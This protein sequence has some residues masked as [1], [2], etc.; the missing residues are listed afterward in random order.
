M[1]IKACESCSMPVDS[2]KYCCYCTTPSG[3]LEPFEKRF[4]ERIAYQ[5][6]DKPWLSRE[7]AERET[8]GFMRSMPAWREHPRVLERLAQR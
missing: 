7:Q 2:A 5:L 3:E 6:Y 8:I 4:E 1:T